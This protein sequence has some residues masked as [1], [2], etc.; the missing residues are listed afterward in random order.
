MSQVIILPELTFCTDPWF[1]RT[2]TAAY[3]LFCILL[4]NWFG[5]GLPIIQ[6]FILEEEK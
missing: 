1:I 2:L 6:D 3:S 4:F 5:Y